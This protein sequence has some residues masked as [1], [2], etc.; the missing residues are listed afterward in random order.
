MSRVISL[1]EERLDELLAARALVGLTP[2]EESELTEL[3]REFAGRRADELDRVV[4]AVAIA[5]LRGSLEPLPAHLA[6]RI[7]AASPA[8]AAVDRARGDVAKPPRTGRV[9]AFAGWLAAAA[10]LALAIGAWVLRPRPLPAVAKGPVELRDELLAS[11]GVLRGEWSATAD[12]A[13]RGASGDI[14]WDPASQ[15]GTMRF[16]GLAKNDPHAVQYQ[17][18]IFDKTRD[19]RYPIDGGVFDVDRDTG[20][21]VVAIHAQLVVNDPGLFAVTAEKAGGVVVSSRERIVVTAT[22]KPI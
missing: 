14:V 3:L 9:I 12:P 7:E 17:L 20:D 5:G 8:G 16:R 15:R 2:A 10:C 6:G 19:Q 4:A 13:S 1:R 21:V 22:P 18:W 11:K